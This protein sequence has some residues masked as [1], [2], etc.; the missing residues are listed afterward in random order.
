M[1]EGTAS[2]PAWVAALAQWGYFF[3]LLE[4]KTENIR[5]QF[6]A[7]FVGI[8]AQL[9]R[10]KKFCF[11]PGF[12]NGTVRKKS[13]GLLFPKPLTPCIRWGCQHNLPAIPLLQQLYEQSCG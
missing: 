10:K 3:S 5:A 7:V 6:R 13:A 2:L 8:A 11:S 9:E 1:W 4:K 12:E